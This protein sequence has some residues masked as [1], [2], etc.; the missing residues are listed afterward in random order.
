MTGGKKHA[1]SFTFRSD[2]SVSVAEFIAD[3]DTDA[4]R[5]FHMRRVGTQELEI[6]TDELD[7]GTNERTV[8]I[9]TVPGIKLPRVVRGLVPNGK[10]EFVDTRRFK[11]GAEKTPPFAQEF[12][13]VNNIT[14][15]S[16]VRGVITV[17]ATGENT[18]AVEVVGECQVSLK[19]VGGIIENIV[20]DGIRK[21]YEVL[22]GIVDE[23]MEHKKTMVIESVVVPE[24]VEQEKKP[25]RLPKNL[26]MESFYSAREVLP[27]PPKVE[28]EPLPSAANS[29]AVVSKKVTRRKTTIVFCCVSRPKVGDEQVVVV[30]ESREEFIDARDELNP[31]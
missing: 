3:K 29:G 25:W 7:A 21:S 24:A 1:K 17:F 22:P 18:C 16:I 10:V 19:A 23:W 26:S 5:S 12:T 2:L 11:N 13:T 14:K 6:L 9:R 30:E 8:V 31:K 15:H 28:K 4:Y 27:S 20:V